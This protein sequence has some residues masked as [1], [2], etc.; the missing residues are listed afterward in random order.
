MFQQFNLLPRTTALR[1]VELPLVYAG[2]GR[3]ER[4]KRAREALETVGLSDRMGHR[5]DELSGGQQQRVAIARALVNQPSIILADEPT[6]NLDTEIGR[7]DPAHLSAAQRAGHH[8]DLCH[9][10]PRDR[11]LQP[12]HRSACAMG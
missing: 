9:A 8:R 12:A 1:Q 3:R 6:G 11:R 2:V 4:R 10:R 5:P 7:G